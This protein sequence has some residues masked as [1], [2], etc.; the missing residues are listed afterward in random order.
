MSIQTPR[1]IGGSLNSVSSIAA[2]EVIFKGLGMTPTGAMRDVSQICHPDS[3]SKSSC[4]CTPS[5]KFFPDKLTSRGKSKMGSV[6]ETSPQSVS[7]IS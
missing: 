2:A 6:D 5:P 3:D 4:E 7:E 1:A